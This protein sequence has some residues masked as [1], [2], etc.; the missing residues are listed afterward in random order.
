VSECGY[1]SL[2]LVG[3]QLLAEHTAHCVPVPGRGIGL[4][5]FTAQIHFRFGGACLILVRLGYVRSVI[6]VLDLGQSGGP[7]VVQ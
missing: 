4:G 6:R 7:G 3:L 5:S 2:G 1:L